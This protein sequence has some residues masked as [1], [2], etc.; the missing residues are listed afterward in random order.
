MLTVSSCRRSSTSPYRRG[1][2][3]F[4]GVIG[5]RAGSVRGAGTGSAIVLCDFWLRFLARQAKA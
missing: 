4:G 1:G 5:A 2:G 3:V